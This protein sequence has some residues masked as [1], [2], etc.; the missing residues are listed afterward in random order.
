[1]LGRRF[2]HRGKATFTPAPGG[3]VMKAKRRKKLLFDFFEKKIFSRE[4]Q[5]FLKENCWKNYFFSE[6]NDKY[7]KP[8]F[9]VKLTTFWPS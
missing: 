9:L 6:I 4:K 7:K 5:R 2:V 1:M 8:S 3:N